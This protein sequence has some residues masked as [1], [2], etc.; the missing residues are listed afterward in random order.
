M[1]Q[2]TSTCL[3]CSTEIRL[4][5]WLAAPLI[6]AT[7]EDYEARI[8]RKDAEVKRREAEVHPGSYYVLTKLS[9]HQADGGPTQE[10]KSVSI[11]TFPVLGQSPAPVQ[12]GD[13]AFYDPALG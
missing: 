12:P 6:R 2:P 3:S 10:A 8:A 7:R 11:E 9:D 13:G 4:T 5:E 1:T